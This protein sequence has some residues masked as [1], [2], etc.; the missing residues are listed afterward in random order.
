MNKKILI[1]VASLAMAGL[2]C[3]SNEPWK[4][5][6]YQQWDKADLALILN[7]S[8]WVKKLDVDVNWKRNSSYGDQSA[9]PESDTAGELRGH[10][11]G[12]KGGMADTA[13]PDRSMDTTASSGGTS[14][15]PR[16]SFIIRWYSSRV[17]REALARGAVLSGRISEAEGA[18]LL[19]EPVTDYEIIVFGQDMTPFQNL[20]E[21]QLKSA[22]Y[23][24]GKQSRQ[25]VAP[26]S[27][28]MNKSPNGRT[29]SLAFLFPRK[30]SS[31]AAVASEEEKGLEFGC[32]LKG[33]DL[34][35]TFETRKMVDE[36]GPDF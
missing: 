25:R 11:A 7:D 12:S 9:V 16:A 18:K 6:P 33:L 20:T 36:T 10:M 4:S 31:G 8:P 34:H 27:V 19:A 15:S 5:K 32:K 28:R 3:A 29:N 22:S 2:A 26:V 21:D 30:T 1:G 13:P 24:E 23:L 17:I 14:T 35:N